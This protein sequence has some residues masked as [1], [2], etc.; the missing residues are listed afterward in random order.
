MEHSTGTERSAKDFDQ[1]VGLIRSIWLLASDFP[2]T[3]R[4]SED[5]AVE[6]VR[7]LGDDFF[8]R[9]GSY[10]PYLI[11]RC[12]QARTWRGPIHADE[13]FRMFCRVVLG[14]E[15]WS[16]SQKAWISELEA[17]ELILNLSEEK[18][19]RYRSAEETGDSVAKE[20]VIAECKAIIYGWEET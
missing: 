8:T 16:W 18:A 17:I 3:D 13:F 14:K 4:E 12:C 10:V 19:S 9:H 7:V 20:S 11:R 5:R 2:I 15:I 1:F 6:W